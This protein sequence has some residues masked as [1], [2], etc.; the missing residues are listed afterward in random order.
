M[1]AAP[2]SSFNTKK[3]DDR[4]PRVVAAGKG[5]AP[6]KAA[7]S[8]S[9]KSFGGTAMKATGKAKAPQKL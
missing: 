2:S 1:K 7:T 6:K 4:A 5:A 8:M 9:S 3:F